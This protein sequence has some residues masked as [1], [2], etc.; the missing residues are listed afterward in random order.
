MD[1]MEN[2]MDQKSADGNFPAAQVTGL[3]SELWVKMFFAA[4][5]WSTGEYLIDDGYDLFVTPPK[6]KFDGSSFLVQVKGKANRQKG[7][8][9]APVSRARLRDYSRNAMPVFIFRVF[10][11]ENTAYCVHAQAI[12]QANPLLLKGKGTANVRFADDAKVD[13]IGDFLQL[14]EQILLPAHKRADGVNSVV[15]SR[16][17]YLSELDDSFKVK[18]SHDGSGSTITIEQ[19]ESSSAETRLEGKFGKTEI[20]AISE[21][22][23]YGQSAT[24]SSDHISLHGSKLFSEL[25]LDHPQSATLELESQYRQDCRVRLRA[26]DSHYS[27]EDD[28]VI[29]SCLRRGTRGFTIEST[30]SGPIAIRIRGIG[31]KD[32]HNLN[33]HI[34]LGP[35]LFDGE[36]IAYKSDL[37]II[38]PW[39]QRTLDIGH[40]FGEIS[41]KNRP[42]RFSAPVSD[43]SRHLLRGLSILGK[44]HHI[45]RITGSDYILPDCLKVSTDESWLVHAAYRML[46]GETIEVDLVSADIEDIEPNL[47]PEP[48][49]FVVSHVFPITVDGRLVAEVPM[50]FQLTNYS[51]QAVGEDRVGT[52]TQLPESTAR[53]RI[54]SR[55]R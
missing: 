47:G 39:A 16:E 30:S 23:L 26:D 51:L 25:G 36:P 34:D 15:R 41:Q 44:I 1:F 33:L 11:N 28:F 18:I 6:S 32:K 29:R 48:R 35:S 49:E 24:V 12:T 5:G 3:M 46:K 2:S 10:P 27:F 45:C 53:V 9:F 37:G 54:D 19:A 52:I 42:V 38:G 31:D 20:A 22:I 40:L 13:S 55:E 7:G 17:N 14:A 50:L 4:A 43:E 8:V 21:L